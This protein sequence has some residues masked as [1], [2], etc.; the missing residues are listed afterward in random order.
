MKMP[1]L[2]PLRAHIQQQDKLVKKD[3]I[4]ID[5]QNNLNLKYF[6]INKNI[7]NSKNSVNLSQFNINTKSPYMNLTNHTTS[8]FS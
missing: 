1:P 8:K 4:I 7:E 6:K 3:K 2:N 5:N